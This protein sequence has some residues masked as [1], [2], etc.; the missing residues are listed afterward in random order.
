MA[1]ELAGGD[2]AGIASDGAAQQGAAD[3]ASGA[4]T[5]E[6]FAD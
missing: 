1:A 4:K 2:G 3:T 6:T 5:L